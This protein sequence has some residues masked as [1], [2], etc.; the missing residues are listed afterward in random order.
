MKV[1]LVH[2]GSTS[3]LL[4]WKIFWD[5]WP[6]D[7]HRGDWME[8]YSQHSRST[9]PQLIL[10]QCRRGWEKP[11]HVLSEYMDGWPIAALVLIFCWTDV[12]HLIIVYCRLLETLILCMCCNVYEL[13][14]CYLFIYVV[15]IPKYKVSLKTKFSQLWWFLVWDIYEIGELYVCQPRLEARQPEYKSW[16]LYILCN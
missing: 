2:Q 4:C 11:K 13:S 9:K 16:E 6:W 5:T 10:P 7:F 1:T 15:I 14:L 8:N 12:T 3:L